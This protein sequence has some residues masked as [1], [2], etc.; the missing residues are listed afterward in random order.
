MYMKS[1]FIIEF[2]QLLLN[3]SCPFVQFRVNS[4]IPN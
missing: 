4:Y 3:S 2:I 1:K